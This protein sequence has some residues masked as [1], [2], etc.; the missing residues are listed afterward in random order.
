[1]KKSAGRICVDKKDKT[2]GEHSRG[3]IRAMEGRK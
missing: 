1:V 3:H 2:N